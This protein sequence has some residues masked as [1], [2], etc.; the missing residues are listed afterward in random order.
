MVFGFAQPKRGGG[1]GGGGCIEIEIEIEISSL[2][3]F[4]V[5]ISQLID[6]FS[7]VDIRLYLEQ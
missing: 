6:H 2:I 4:P 3:I 7:I 1:G 5:I